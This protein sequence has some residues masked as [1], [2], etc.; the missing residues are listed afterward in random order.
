MSDEQP[1]VTGGCLC[2][3]VRF[4]YTGAPN[5]IVHCHCES[6]RRATASP[7]TTFVS[8]PCAAITFTGTPK[9]FASSPGVK[10]GFCGTCGS[11]LTYENDD[12]PDEVHVYAA[13]LDEPARAAVAPSRHVF[14]DAQLPWFEVHDALPRY[15]GT[16][17]RGAKPIG[18]GPA[19]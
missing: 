16:S 13:V 17:G 12:L 15:G 18:K 9:Y 1:A 11:P 10:R 4:T 3:A 6:C 5:W 2:G 19:A 8:V 7:M 14:V